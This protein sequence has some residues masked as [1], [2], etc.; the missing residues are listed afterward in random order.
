M[1]QGEQP[2]AASVDRRVEAIAQVGQGHAELPRSG[3]SPVSPGGEGAGIGRHAPEGTRHPVCAGGDGPAGRP[4]VRAS[5][6]TG[7]SPRSRLPMPGTRRG[8]PVRVRDGAAMRYRVGARQLARRVVPRTVPVLAVVFGLVAVLDASGATVSDTV[9]SGHLAPVLVVEDGGR[10]LFDGATLRPGGTTEACVEVRYEGPRGGALGPVA[11][12]LTA[13]P[14]ADGMD[15]AAA[16]SLRV[17]EGSVPDGGACE[18]FVPSATVA[19]DVVLRDVLD[20][21]D[22]TGRWVP[23]DDDPVRTYRLRVTLTPDAPPG[24]VLRDVDVRWT[25]RGT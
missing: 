16:L 6:E 20:A 15:L 1:R 13:S 23:G 8:R 2:F 9:P 3:A 17:E 14:A 19:S 24:A 7:S 4:H 21:D 18:G 11:V 5:A 12:G 22:L 25:V 10:P